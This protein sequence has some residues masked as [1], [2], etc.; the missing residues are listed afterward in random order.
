MPVVTRS[1]RYDGLFRS[2]TQE[3]FDFD[4]RSAAEHDW[5]PTS[6]TWQGTT[7]F[8]V[9]TQDHGRR[10]RA[11]TT[12]SE[13]PGQTQ[14]D[15]ERPGHNAVARLLVGLAVTVTIVATLTVAMV[16]W[17]SWDRPGGISGK[18]TTAKPGKTA[19]G[20][21]GGSGAPSDHRGARTPAN[22]RTFRDGAWVVGADIAPGKYRS[23]GGKT[24]TWS[25][26]RG[27]GGTPEE[28]IATETA[29]GHRVVT[30]RSSDAGFTSTGCG[31]W[32]R[33]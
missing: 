26:L 2:Q 18:P 8:V 29:N 27:L 24:C 3:Q 25:R 33:R 31:T 17:N 6:E 13:V 20:L 14:P 30:I 16:G 21:V 15:A 1:Q 19:H 4:V 10:I 11:P 5:Y 7:L 9:Y 22:A 12:D 32:T 28:I 23:S